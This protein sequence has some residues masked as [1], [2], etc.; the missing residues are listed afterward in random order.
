[1]T[2]YSWATWPEAVREQIALLQDHLLNTLDGILIGLYLHGSLAFGCFNPDRSDIDLLAVTAR[3]M[4]LEEKRRVV[5]LLLHTSLAPQ[6]I[7]ISFLVEPAIHTSQH[8]LPFDLHYSEDWR[9]RLHQELSDDEWL[10]WNDFTRRDHDL[11]TH[12]I[13]TLARG[14]TLYGKPMRETLPAVPQEYYI[15]SIV[16]DFEDALQHITRIPVHFVLN[17]CRVYAYLREGNVLS[18]DE[19]GDW[20]LRT[21]PDTYHGLIEQALEIYRGDRPDR[22]FNSADLDRFAIYMQ[23]QIQNVLS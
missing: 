6:P 19:G 18:K 12:I 10:H 22:P 3:A 13:V 17:A 2:Q 9:E 11:A 20:A 8:P 4:T 14:V 7:E 23:E 1:M 5:E 21:L 15:E 16:R